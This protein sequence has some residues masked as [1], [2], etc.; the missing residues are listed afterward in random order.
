MQAVGTSEW[1][2][3]LI[4]ARDLAWRHE[5]DS[6]RTVGDFRGR[7]ISGI[8]GLNLSVKSGEFLWILGNSGAGKTSL[9]RLLGVE[10]MATSG[11]LDILGTQISH[12]TSRRVLAALR[13]RIG[14]VH[15]DF[16]LIRDL[17]VLENISL[18]LRFQ[19]KTASEISGEAMALIEWLGLSAQ[20]GYFPSELSG[21][22]Q[23]RVAI[24]RAVIMR[25]DILL[26]DE[27]FNAQEKPQAEK[28][29]RM[30]QE[31]AVMGTSVIVAT[32]N[33]ALVEEFPASTFR[34]GCEESAG[35][36]A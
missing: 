19:R 13:R 8:A 30:M 12:K 11:Q 33:A 1:R 28:L 26:A 3:G 29:V 4:I 27:P 6:D 34:L 25:P 5:S 2:Q 24:A 17:T 18:P 21:G 32:H 31:L 20:S 14:I 9:L 16:R 15:Q 23:Q 36:R 35:G 10:T 22:E 7:Q